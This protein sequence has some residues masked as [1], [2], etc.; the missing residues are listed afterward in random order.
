M[1]LAIIEKALKWL[2]TKQ[3]TVGKFT[4]VG[5]IYDTNLPG[6]SAEGIALTAY[7]ALT[8][9]EANADSDIQTDSRFSTGMNIALD[10][11]TRNLEGLQDPYSVAL[12]TYVLTRAD[13]PLKLG[14]FNILEGLAKVSGKIK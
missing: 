6:Q 7:V 8:M 14:G 12:T 13:H 11:L 5:K 9:I 4:E 3:E 1:N 10:Y 2:V